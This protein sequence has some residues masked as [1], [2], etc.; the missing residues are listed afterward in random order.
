[1][2]TNINE[3]DFTDS[4]ADLAE[5]DWIVGPVLAMYKLRFSSLAIVLQGTK[6]WSIVDRETREFIG[7]CPSLAK[8]TAVIDRRLGR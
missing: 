3:F 5:C 4:P 1:M 8:A 7:C 6:A 2:A